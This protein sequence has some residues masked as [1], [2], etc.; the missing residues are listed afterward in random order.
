MPSVASRG[1]RAFRGAPLRFALAWVAAPDGDAWSF[2][3][4]LVKEAGVLVSPGEFYGEQ[5]KGHIRLAM[6]QP[7][8]QIEV[9]ERRLGL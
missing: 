4:R 8:S 2:A 7:N 6:V 3:R 9:I 1:C 5:G